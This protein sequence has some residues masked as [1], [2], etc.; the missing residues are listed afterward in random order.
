M[1]GPTGVIAKGTGRGTGRYIAIKNAG[2]TNPD[3]RV[4]NVTG[5]NGRF[6]HAYMFNPAELGPLDLAFGAFDQNAYAAV[7]RTKLNQVADASGTGHGTNA[8]VP[9]ASA[10]LLI[11]VDTQ[12][13]DITNFGQARFGNYF[14]PQVPIVFRG[15]TAQEVAA[16][17]FN[18]RGLPAQSTR[19]A[20]G[21]P[22]TTAVNGFTRAKYRKFASRYPMTLHAY[23][24]TATPATVTFTLDAS[25]VTDQTGTMITAFRFTPSTGLCVPATLTS[26]VIATRSVTVAPTS[27]SFADDDWVYVLYQ[28]FDLLSTG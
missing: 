13:A 19:E 28:S 9:G 12:D 14:Y 27:G 17:D 3:P 8:P 16:A 21:V 4:T 22:F 7:S 11:T 5:D 15:E 6:L 1:A 25:P 20:W 18:Y 26:V 2:V 23:H 10:G 24:V